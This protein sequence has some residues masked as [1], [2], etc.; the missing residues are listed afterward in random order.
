MRILYYNPYY[1]VPSFPYYSMPYR[2]YP[3]VHPKKFM[4]SA[5]RTHALLADA[6]L[7]LNRIS[8]STAFAGQLMSA[9]QKSDSADVGRMLTGTGIQHIPRVF[10]TPDGLVLQFVQKAPGNQ[11]PCCELQMKMRWS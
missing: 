11:E 4:D 5:M 6:Q 10:Y 8:R 7:L 1:V 2:Q 9:A 3:A